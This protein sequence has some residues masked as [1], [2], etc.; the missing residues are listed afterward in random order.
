MAKAVVIVSDTHTGSA[1]ALFP[2]RFQLSTGSIVS[3][4]VGQ[5]YLLQ[6][7]RDFEERI[8]ERFEVLVLNG[9]IINGQNRRESAADLTEVDPA[10]QQRAALEL[11]EPIAA[12]AEKVYVA[13]G[14]TYHTGEVA[15][16][17][18]QLAYQLGA[19]PD[20]SG[21][22]AWDW[23]LLDIDGVRLDVAHHQSVVMRYVTMP[24][25]REQ[26]FDKI[27]ADWKGGS[28]HLIVRSHAHRYV[29]AHVELQQSVA[30]ASWQLQSRYVRRGRLPNR[31]FSRYIGGLWLEVH[32]ERVGQSEYCTTLHP[33]LYRHPQLARASYVEA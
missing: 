16:W 8:P 26:Q 7:W 12:R 27:I 15:R 23:L 29:E 2:A 33:V 6:C 20:S 5:Q 4:N 25:E 11:L 10:W 21:H 13:Q 31:M 28:A 1:Y 14:S 32:P 18:E 24:L 19:E 9:D 30:T 3:L 17:E 22:Y